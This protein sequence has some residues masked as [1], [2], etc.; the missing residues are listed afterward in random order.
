MQ[1]MARDE[2][3]TIKP[4]PK[5]EVQILTINTEHQDFIEFTPYKTDSGKKNA[6]AQPKNTKNA[7]DKPFRIT[8]LLRPTADLFPVF[9]SINEDA[10]KSQLY[11]RKEAIDILWK[12]V[13]LK[14]LSK[15]GAKTVTLDLPLSR[16][17][18]RKQKPEG[19]NVT[20]EELATRFTA[21]L[22]ENYE[23]CRE[24]VTNVV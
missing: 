12:Y 19:D 7:D 4:L 6:D 23:I 3:V 15:Q 16:G 2:L 22:Q 8:K 17:A 5:G 14:E 13:E 1:A 21:A 24:G 20:K 10:Q 11:T 18:F 9:S